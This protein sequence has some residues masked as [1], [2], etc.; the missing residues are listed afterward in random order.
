MLAN[1]VHFIVSETY[2]INEPTT[3]SGI[4]SSLWKRKEVNFKQ[5]GHSGFLQPLRFFDSKKC[6]PQKLQAAEAGWIFRRQS[7]RGRGNNKS[8]NF[9]R[10]WPAGRL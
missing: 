3:R 4:C 7:G 5:S 9:A 6:S 2:P 8:K 1:K 10:A